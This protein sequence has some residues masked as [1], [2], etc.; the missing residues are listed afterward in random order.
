MPTVYIALGSN[1]GDREANLKEAMR[2][3]GESGVEII[4]V[5]SM[6]E[7]EPVDYLEQ[8]WFFNAVL[9]AQTD[10]A[11]MELLATLRR[12]ETEMG[13][14]KLVRK[15]PR[16]IDLDILLY[17]DETIHTAELEV[18]HPRML[19]RNFVLAPLAEIAPRLRHAGWDA[20]ASELLAN[21]SDQSVVRRLS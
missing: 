6:Y 3:L 1:I 14:K 10:L 16:L 5:S 20:S 13:S 9:E 18:P 4:K 11:P 15:G 8:P 2:L 21:S 17:G 7:T 12:I 19:Q